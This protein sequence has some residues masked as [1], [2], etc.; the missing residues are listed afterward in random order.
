MREH[1]PFSPSYWLHS[2]FESICAFFRI[3]PEPC[4]R[5]DAFSDVRFAALWQVRL[6]VEL[7]RQRVEF[8]ASSSLPLPSSTSNDDPSPKTA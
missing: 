7:K 8:T 1:Q 3:S 2:H 5:E 4:H 6:D